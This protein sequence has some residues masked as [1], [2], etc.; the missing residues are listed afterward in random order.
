H[1]KE[2]NCANINEKV[3]CVALGDDDELN[4]AETS[5]N[6]EQ[7]YEFPDGQVITVGHA[8]DLMCIDD[9]AVPKQATK[10]TDLVFVENY[11]VQLKAATND[12]KGGFTPSTHIRTAKA[13]LSM[14]EIKWEMGKATNDAKVECAT[15]IETGDQAEVV[16]APKIPV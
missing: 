2:G 3:S 6:L 1:R 11:P 15:F 13:H 9:A 4:K 5:G 8:G 16:F 14:L 10:F 7:K 12:A